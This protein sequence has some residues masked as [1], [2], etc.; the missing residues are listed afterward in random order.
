[1]EEIN[2]GAIIVQALIFWLVYKL[3]QISIIHKIGKDLSEAIKERG[4]KLERD[5]EG[6]ISIS[7]EPTPLK[8]ERVDSQYFAYTTAGEFLAQGSDFRGLFENIK[9]RYPNKSFRLDKYQA[10]LTEEETG[11]LVKSIFDV[12]GDGEKKHGDTRQ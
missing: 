7:K 1:M 5:D 12:F 10:E 8:I 4:L 2:W 6:N 11:K 3:G 9:N